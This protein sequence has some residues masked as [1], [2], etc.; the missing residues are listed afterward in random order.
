MHGEG[1]RIDGLKAC[2]GHY[3]Q[4][5]F[6]LCLLVYMG[7]V[8]LRARLNHKMEFLH[9]RHRLASFY[10]ALHGITDC[11]TAEAALLHFTA[12]ISRTARETTLLVHL[13]LAIYSDLLSMVD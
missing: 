12:S 4:G 13:S 9:A 8:V 10:N 3:T 5:C 6:I 11:I 2:H 1:R 7:E